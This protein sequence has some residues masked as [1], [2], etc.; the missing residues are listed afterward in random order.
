LT[1]M[2]VQGTSSCQRVYT[3]LLILRYEKL[4]V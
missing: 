1:R 3:A 2:Q 4:F